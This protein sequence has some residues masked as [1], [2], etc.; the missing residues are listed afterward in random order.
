MG[1]ANLA[2]VKAIVDIIFGV[3]IGLIAIVGLLYGGYRAWQG[4]S[5]DQPQEMRQGLIVIAGT[6][7]AIVLMLLL[8]TPILGLAGIK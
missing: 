8:K 5:A 2:N 3:V 7:M 4:F 1:T 6:V